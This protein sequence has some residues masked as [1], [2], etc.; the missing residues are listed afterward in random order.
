MIGY[1]VTNSDS[2]ETVTAAA[3]LQIERALTWLAD[4]AHEQLDKGERRILRRLRDIAMDKGEVLACTMVGRGDDA[5][6]LAV[7]R[8]R[9]A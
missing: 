7:E 5:R 6:V 1:A 4:R 3:G 9:P 8:H 2:G